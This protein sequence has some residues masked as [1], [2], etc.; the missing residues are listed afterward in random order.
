VKAFV[1][2][3]DRVAYAKRCTAALTEAGFDV[4]IVDQGSTWPPALAW[5]Q[6]ARADGVPVMRRGGGHPR[7]LWDWAPFRGVR[8][9]GRYLVTD[10]DVLPSDCCPPD[11]PDR[12]GSLLDRNPEVVK[13]GLGLRTD[14][15]PVH[16]Q[17]RDQVIAWESQFLAGP[18]EDRGLTVHRAGIDTTLALYREGS[19]FS[20]DT[21]TNIRTGYPYLADHLAWHEDLDDPG[22]EIYWYYEHAEPGIAH[23]TVRG[24]S[25]FGD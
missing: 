25:T 8:G 20:L 10:C 13:A 6:A 9:G 1:I 2:F 4:V 18:V 14:N 15:I 19:G 23:W 7:G 5:L 11:W 3:R 24:R 22:E 16:Y 21:A 17:R 12:L